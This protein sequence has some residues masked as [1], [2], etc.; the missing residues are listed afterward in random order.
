MTSARHLV[1]LHTPLGDAVF[2]SEG[3]LVRAFNV[4]DK[5]ELMVY[6]GH[7]ADV[8]CMLLDN[9]Q[10]FTGSEVNCLFSVT[11]CM[12]SLSS[13]VIIC[14]LFAVIC[15]YSTSIC[16]CRPVYFVS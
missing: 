2:V 14:C 13:C 16:I 15:I 8:T 10:L 5:K 7:I 11:M 9:Q 6:A 1:V 4:S 12:L 3:K